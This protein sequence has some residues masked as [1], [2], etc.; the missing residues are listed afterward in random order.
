MI[1]ASSLYYAI[2]ICLLVSICCMSILV[3]N[4]YFKFSIDHFEH[5][6]SLLQQHRNV[7]A[8]CLNDKGTRL[9]QVDKELF[10]PS[11]TYSQKRQKWGGYEI[12]TLSTASGPDSLTRTYVLGS[13]PDTT[14]ALYLTDKNN[15]LNVGGDTKIKGLAFLPQKGVKK[16]YLN[17]QEFNTKK[18][19]PPIERRNSNDFILSKSII[20]QDKEVG[21]DD[22]SI[23]Y[24]SGMVVQNDFSQAT[25]SIV[26]NENRIDN[27][28]LTGNI[29]LTSS[30]SLMIGRG[31]KLDYVI[32]KAPI[33]VIE[34]GFKGRLQIKASKKIVVEE[35]V[36][37]LYPS[38]LFMDQQEGIES[39]IVMKKG[40]KLIGE[41][42]A[43][44]ASSNLGE[45][46]NHVKIHSESTVFGEVYCQGSVELKGIV[47]GSLITNS[48][49]LQYKGGYYDN[50][51]IGGE[52]DIS[53]RPKSFLNCAIYNQESITYEIVAEL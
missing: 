40:S 49:H 20:F 9:E 47:K 3:A 2:V 51:L 53:R 38:L 44:N 32:V 17:V 14:L 12:L 45:V 33:V 30:D 13:V 29:I 22:N 41:I 23:K 26:I 1:K 50:Y 5:Q 31:V 37:L 42:I 6:E 11:L 27:I 4:H 48:F 43:K 52:I 36:V 46:K 24:A 21:S 35:E 39:S 8:M 25:K 7:L 19:I 16:A 18:G 15:P 34:K 10:P 28:D